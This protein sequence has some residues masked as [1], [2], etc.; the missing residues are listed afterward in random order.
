M[1]RAL[2]ARRLSAALGRKVTADD[3]DFIEGNYVCLVGGKVYAL[4][5]GNACYAGNGLWMKNGREWRDAWENGTEP[6]DLDDVPQRDGM[7]DKGASGF[8]TWPE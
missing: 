2:A 5:A 7:A 4:Y 8:A 6:R 1:D 3:I